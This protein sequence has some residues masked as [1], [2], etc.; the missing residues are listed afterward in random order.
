MKKSRTAGT[1]IDPL[2]F[3]AV[4]LFFAGIILTIMADIKYGTWSLY[5]TILLII[6]GIVLALITIPH[7]I[8]AIMRCGRNLDKRE[9]GG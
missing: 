9:K 8:N 7:V 2:P 4:I 6:A 1:M 5:S 3:I